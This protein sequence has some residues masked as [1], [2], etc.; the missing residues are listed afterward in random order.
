MDY[1]T[2]LCKKHDFTRIYLIQQ[3]QT[4]IVSL[5]DTFYSLT[6]KCTLFYI[7]LFLYT[8]SIRIDNYLDATTIRVESN[9]TFVKYYYREEGLPVE[10]SRVNQRVQKIQAS[11]HLKQQLI[12]GLHSNF[13]KI[14]DEIDKIYIGFIDTPELM[15]KAKFDNGIKMD[16]NSSA[17]WAVLVGASFYTEEVMPTYPTLEAVKTQIMHTMQTKEILDFID[18]RPT[19]EIAEQLSETFRKHNAEYEYDNTS[20]A[21][22]STHDTSPSTQ[23]TEASSSFDDQQLKYMIVLSYLIEI[24]IRFFCSLSEDC[25]VYDLTYPPFRVRLDIPRIDVLCDGNTFD[26]HFLSNTNLH[27]KCMKWWQLFTSLIQKG[28]KPKFEIN[29]FCKNSGV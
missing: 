20:D 29:Q 13:A 24:K 5:C 2:Y 14:I 8:E 9:D 12:E 15:L 4:H 26:F 11:S 22:Q 7:L 27:L 6:G 1:F 21:T 18:D 16:N 25:K 17:I 28:G 19:S 10:V 23:Y 3:D